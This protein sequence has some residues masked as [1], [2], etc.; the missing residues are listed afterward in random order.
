MEHLRAEMEH[1]QAKM[2]HRR[3]KREH[4]RAEKSF[5]R[6]RSVS[7]GTRPKVGRVRLPVHSRAMSKLRWGIIG[8]GNI[9]RQFADGVKHS[10][11]GTIASV[12]SRTS[13]AAKAFGDKYDISGR[14]GD[15]ASLLRDDSVDAIYL[16]LPNNLHHEWTIR[17]LEAGKH[18]LC[19]KP[20]AISAAEAI[21]MYAAARKANRVLIE[22]FMY[23]AHPQTAKVVELIRSGAIGNV[24]EIRT[25]FCYRVRNWEGNIRFSKD[26]HGGA[27]MDVGCYCVSFS[28]LIAGCDPDRVHAVSRLHE[29]G[30]DEQTAGVMHY[31]NGITA[32]FSVGM[33]TQMD[34]TAYVCGDE[35]YLA[36]AW[37]WKP[38]PPMTKIEIKQSLP[39][40]QD[41][42]AAATTTGPR[43]IEVANEKPLYAIEA[44]SFAATVLDGAEPFVTEAESIGVM[45]TVEEIKAMTGRG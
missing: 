32:T 4:R 45:R 23:R 5:G 39:P 44:D 8:T 21:E 3:L 18:V 31:P 30:V 16:S 41:T 11:R 9:A 37:P 22:A 26:L 35:G 19:E 36:I 1:R 10:D 13:D 28:R 25:S 7:L 2:E 20:V 24:K 12:A 27:M 6:I 43:T 34:N 42:S 38:A 14:H 17:A 29:S 40:R 15:Y 33:M